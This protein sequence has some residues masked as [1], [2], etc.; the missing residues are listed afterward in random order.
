M[1]ESEA[2]KLLHVLCANGQQML[3]KVHRGAVDDL[4]ARGLASLIK[5]GSAVGATTKGYE[6]HRQTSAI[7]GPGQYGKSYN[8]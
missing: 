5:K 6:L 7:G 4:V 1:H 8:R 2:L 3:T